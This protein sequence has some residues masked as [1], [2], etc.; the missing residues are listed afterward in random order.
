MIGIRYLEEVENGME[1]AQLL[2]LQAPQGGAHNQQP[3]NQGLQVTTIKYGASSAG[4]LLLLQASQGGAHNQQ[5][6]N[7]GLQVRLQPLNTGH[8][9]LG[10]CCCCKRP[11]VVQTTN[12]SST[13]VCR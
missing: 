7:Q 5:P 6:L 1:A 3:L 4:Q 8:P 11:R 2:L 10:S 13:R 12:S 9:V